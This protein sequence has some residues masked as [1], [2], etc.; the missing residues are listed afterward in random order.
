MTLSTKITCDACQDPKLF[1]RAHLSVGLRPACPGSRRELHFCDVECLGRFT[2]QIEAF[3]R[4]HGQ[5]F[6]ANRPT[7]RA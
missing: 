6:L 3:Q 4:D 2:T 7:V 5:L 1:G